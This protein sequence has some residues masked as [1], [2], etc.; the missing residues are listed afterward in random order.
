MAYDPRIHTAPPVPSHQRRCFVP[1]RKNF[2]NR[3]GAELLAFEIQ[4]FWHK[5]GYTQVRAEVVLGPRSNKG[6]HVA[7]VRTNLVNGLPPELVKR[8]K[9][10]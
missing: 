8:G 4:E 2:C 9:V 5:R 1:D 7:V 3:Q 10:T 6:G